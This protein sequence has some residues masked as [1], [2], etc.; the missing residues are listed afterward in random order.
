MYSYNI[1]ESNPI[2]KSSA[3][4][5]KFGNNVKTDT[6][7]NAAR[8]ALRTVPTSVTLFKAGFSGLLCAMRM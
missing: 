4:D 1:D 3:K 7:S 8:P 5:T 6:T 2:P